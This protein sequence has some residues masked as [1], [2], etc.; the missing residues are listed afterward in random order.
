M[1]DQY[2]DS[3]LDAE[4][5]TVPPLLSQ[6]PRPESEATETEELPIATLLANDP[7]LATLLARYRRAESRLV[8]ASFPSLVLVLIFWAIASAYPSVGTAF[9]LLASI[10]ALIIACLILMPLM[11]ISWELMR[12]A[13]AKDITPADSSAYGWGAIGI[14]VGICLLIGCL[15][16]TAVTA[17]SASIARTALIIME[18]LFLAIQSLRIIRHSSS[19]GN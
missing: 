10:G 11:E 12:K 8:L 3:H 1:T 15:I 17:G 7:K 9:N 2:N 19:T 5:Q 14:W 13:D 4:P 18:L 6:N 16:A